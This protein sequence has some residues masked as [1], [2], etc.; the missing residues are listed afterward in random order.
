[1]SHRITSIKEKCLFYE[2]NIFLEDLSWMVYWKMMC[3]AV[4]KL[5]LTKCLVS[6]TVH[7]KNTSEGD[8]RGLRKMENSVSI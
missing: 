6:S 1:M 3:W 8:V 5:P 7:L 4:P 2:G